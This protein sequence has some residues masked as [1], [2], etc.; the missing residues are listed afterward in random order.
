MILEMRL[1]SLES[2]IAIKNELV[3][4]LCTILL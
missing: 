2:C 4:N 3:V 1:E